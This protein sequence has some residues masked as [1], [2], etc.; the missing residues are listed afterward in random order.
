MPVMMRHS[1]PE[2]R[3]SLTG[4]SKITSVIALVLNS[5][6]LLVAAFLQ[7]RSFVLGYVISIVFVLASF[8]QFVI[9]RKQL[10]L[11][12][13]GLLLF[14]PLLAFYFK[15]DS[16][17]G[18]MFIYKICFKMLGNH[19]M[20]GV[21]WGNFET[22]YGACQ[23]AYFRSNA[24]TVKEFL[25]ADNTRYAFNDYLQFIIEN[26]I[27]GVA[28]L[29]AAL[30]LMV[31][32]I[33][34]VFAN[35]TKYQLLLL[36]ATSQVIAIAIAAMFMHVFERWFFQV[37][38]ITSLLIIVF[39][40]RLQIPGWAF[41]SIGLLTLCAVLWFHFGTYI[42]HYNA[43]KNYNSAKE[44]YSAGFTKESLATYKRLSVALQ[45]D[46][47]FNKDYA[48]ALV[49]NGEYNVAIAVLKRVIR[50]NNSAAFYLKLAECY[51]QTG[52]YAMA[53]QAYETAINMVP[54]RFTG[55]YYLFDFYKK[56]G[57]VQK[58]IVIAQF[59]STMPVKIPSAQITQIKSELRLWL[60]TN[61][62][63]G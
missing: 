41:L 1:L 48:I 55:R 19:F 13:I 3:Q 25:L 51:F 44:L 36:I 52:R 20:T 61:M 10:L 58:A 2:D 22:A 39:Y 5:C 8:N 59:I 32:G 21:G 53:E 35:R 43:Y 34:N 15:T 45:H 40:S 46:V 16:S 12:F 56:T 50:F 29:I 7:S 23:V 38:F 27:T 18:R 49:G 47:Y 33:K 14:F 62:H 9:S 42:T 6:C 54:N 11:L 63:K 26:G 30:I 60:Q 31:R 4:H 28:L 17:L 24:Y 37:I 57:Q